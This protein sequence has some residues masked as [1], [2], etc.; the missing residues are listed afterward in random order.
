MQYTLEQYV[1][2]YGT[3]VKCRSARKCRRK[4]WHKFYDERVPSRQTIHN[5]V[6]ILRSTGLLI[7]QK[8]N[9][10]TQCLL[11]RSY[12]LDDIRARLE[13]TPRKSLKRLAQ[14]TDVSKSSARKATQLLKLRTYKTTVIHTLQPH[15]PAIRVHFFSWFLHSCWRWDQ[16]AVDILFWWSMVSLSG[17][18]KYAK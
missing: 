13:H 14:E 2:L 4:F 18:H 8:Q 12:V 15:D 17:M 1:F 10:S 7:Y 5:L 11:M 9:I 6:N 16:S 3:Y